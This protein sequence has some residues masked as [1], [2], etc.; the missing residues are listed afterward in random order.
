MKQRIKSAVIGLLILGTVI[1]FYGTPVLNLAISVIAILAVDEL[2]AAAG[3]TK[4]RP[5]SY[6]A[7][8]FAGLIPFFGPCF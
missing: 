8:L 4:N 7:L 1:F 5:L 6:A 3:Y 2:I